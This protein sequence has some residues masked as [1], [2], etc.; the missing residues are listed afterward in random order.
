MVYGASTKWVIL[1]KR[2]EPLGKSQVRLK[3]QTE[4]PN[5]N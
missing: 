4:N 1:I 2:R 3:N 5:K